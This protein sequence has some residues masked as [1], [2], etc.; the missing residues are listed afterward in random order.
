M[1]ITKLPL[2]IYFRHIII[3]LCLIIYMSLG[4]FVT[5]TT[6]S[7]FIYVA[8]FIL[9]FLLIYY[10]L[11]LVVFPS[12]FETKRLLFVLCFVAVAS[13]YVLLDFL[14]LKIILPFFGGQ[15]PGINLPFSEFVKG[16]LL[17]FSFVGFSSLG[18]YLNLRSFERAKEGAK[19][20][21]NTISREI[22]FLQNQFNSHLTFNFLNFCYSKVLRSSPKAA[23][24]IEYFS[25]M[26]HYSLNNKPEKY[27][28]LQKE[29][30][31]INH[32]ISVQKC[33]SNEVFAE[34]KVQGETN[35]FT[36]LPKILGIFIENSFKHGTFNDPGNPINISLSIKNNELLFCIKNI[37][38]SKIPISNSGIGLKNVK[39]LLALFYPGSLHQ[40]IINETELDYTTQLTLISE[41]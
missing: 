31:Y 17:L 40:L 37:K 29:V 11:L 21:K 15:T 28:L 4:N 22:I 27:V 13:I 32:F 8:I 18:S 7:K 38:T 10:T 14:H 39:Q 41:S 12:F 36:I 1:K 25:E 26:L 19:K 34:L 3:W 30:D 5:G 33:L 6:I 23:E 20:E 9:C 24:S 35:Q 16:S 2:Q